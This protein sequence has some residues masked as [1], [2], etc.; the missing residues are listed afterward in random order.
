M[1]LVSNKNYF[2]III[3][4]YANEINVLKLK[5]LL[6]MNQDSG[7]PNFSGIE[8]RRTLIKPKFTGY[9]GIVQQ[10]NENYNFWVCRHKTVY[11]IARYSESC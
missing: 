8:S 10:A 6:R 5:Y 9:T 3:I 7:D 2:A 4:L 1:N 11:L